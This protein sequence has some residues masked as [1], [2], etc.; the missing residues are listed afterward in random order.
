M[1]QILLNNQRGKRS[2]NKSNM[3]NVFLSNKSKILPHTSSVGDVNSYDVYL[4][5]R[6]SNN[7]TLL[8]NIK[9]VASNELLNNKTEITNNET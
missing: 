2:T 8:F 4:N 9:V 5:E 6:K 3:L 1:E 7:Y